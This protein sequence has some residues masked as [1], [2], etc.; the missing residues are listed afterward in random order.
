MHR[1]LFHLP[2]SRMSVPRLPLQ[3]R[4]SSIRV[5]KPAT[6]PFSIAST[7]NLKQS[8]THWRRLESTIRSAAE[9]A[10][11]TELKF[12]QLSE[13]FAPRRSLQPISRSFKS[14]L[15]FADHLDGR[16]RLPLNLAC[17]A[18]SGRRSTRFWRLP[19]N[20]PQMQPSPILP[21][22]WKSARDLSMNR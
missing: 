22:S 2:P 17:C 20:L 13:R 1:E 19:T 15:K 3:S 8:K 11:S 18:R 6:S 12:R 5:S 10:S 9:N 7:G 14:C 21:P 4:T 16:P